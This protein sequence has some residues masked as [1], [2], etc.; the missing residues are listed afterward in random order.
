MDHLVTSKNHVARISVSGMTCASCVEL[1][2]HA[3]TQLEGVNSVAVSTEYCR[4]LLCV[5]DDVIAAYV[6]VWRRL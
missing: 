1:V 3:V 5:T 4:V 2:Q 6:L